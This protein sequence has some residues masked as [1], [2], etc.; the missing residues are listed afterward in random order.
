[1]SRL[2][3]KVAIVTGGAR[4]MGAAT[5]RLFVAEGARVLISDVLEDDGAK[6]AAELGDAARFVRHDVSDENAWHATLAQAVDAFGGVDVLVNNAGVLMFKTLAE[7]SKAEFERVI[8]I[9]LVG[10]FLGVKI[11]GQHMLGRRHGSIVNVSSVD[12]MKGANGLGAYA[13]SKWGIRGLTRVAAMEYGHKGVRVNSIHP[14]GIDTAMGNP[15]AE[16]RAELNKRYAMVPLQRVGEPEEV[17]RTSLFLASDESSYLCGAEIA[18]DG[19]MLT[20]QYYVGFPGA[21]GI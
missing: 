6:L 10:C 21:P 7:T 12:G 1:M 18:I 11:V 4:G 15:Y 5:A 17:A 14:G 3:N 20:G 2:K 8:D 9:N 16:A 13:A 19:G